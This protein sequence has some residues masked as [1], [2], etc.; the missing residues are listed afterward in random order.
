MYESEKFC[1]KWNDFQENISSTFSS[2]RSDYDF[3]DVTLVCE[4]GQQ[5]EAHKFILAASSPVFHNMLI[6]N[7]HTHP[8][9][10]MRGLKSDDLVA[11]VDYLYSGEASIEQ[12]NVKAFLVIVDELKVKGL[13]VRGELFDEDNTSSKNCSAVKENFTIRDGIVE[14]ANIKL[15]FVDSEIK[16]EKQKT[17]KTVDIVNNMYSEELKKLDSQ[18]KPLI[19]TGSIIIQN[20]KRKRKANQCKVCGKEGTYK[21]IKDHIELHHIQR[22]SHP[23]NFCNK[24]SKSRNGLRIHHNKTHK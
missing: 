23:C 1:L 4:D 22:V 3:T 24:I 20:R 7:K 14:E 9:I 8:L 16:K 17:K 21:N 12:E 11:I 6:R 2:M 19:M 18:I 15:E 10:Y 13:Y 5:V